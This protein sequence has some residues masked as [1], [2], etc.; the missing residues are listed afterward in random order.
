MLRALLFATTM[1]LAAPALAADFSFADAGPTAEERQIAALLD[2]QGGYSWFD[3]DFGPY[4]ASHV[5]FAGRANVWL[6]RSLSLQF[7]AWDE[8]LYFEGGGDV[9]MYG[10][11]VHAS[12]RDPSSHLV[13]VLASIG[14][15]FGGDYANVGAEGQVYLGNLTLYGQAGYGWGYDNADGQTMPYVHLV[16]RQFLNPDLMIEG[17]AGY[18]SFDTGAGSTD[19]V[20]WETRIEGRLPRTP[21]SAYVAYQGMY[22]DSGGGSL[23]ENAIVGGIRLMTAP[24]LLANDRSG[25]SLVDYNPLF[26]YPTWRD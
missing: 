6:N 2:V 20:R 26:G 23:T 13:G 19:V 14:N 25:A 7:D 24:S 10:G 11:A 16:A 4:E 1:L 17:Q 9:S 12:F 22:E 5:D 8:E 21:L 3:E 18:A 15:S